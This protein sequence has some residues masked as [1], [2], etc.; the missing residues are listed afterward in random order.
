MTDEYV[1]ATLADIFGV[2]LPALALP[3]GV[4][5]GGSSGSNGGNTDES[6]GG[7]GDEEFLGGSKDTI[8]YPP[9][10][11]YLPYMQIINEYD[12]KIS[13]YIKSGAISDELAEII[14]EYLDILTNFA[15]QNANK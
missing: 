6:G 8:Y 5:S 10:E 1:R 2:E 11:K 7:E 13:E 15:Q 9:Q 3:D 4:Q 14:N 12:K